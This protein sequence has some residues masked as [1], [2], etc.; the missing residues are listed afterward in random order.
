MTN[1][2]PAVTSSSPEPAVTS[3]GV[4]QVTEVGRFVFHTVLPVLASSAVMNDVSPPSSSHCRM[5]RFL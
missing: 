5:T 4:V 2:L 1:S 3:A